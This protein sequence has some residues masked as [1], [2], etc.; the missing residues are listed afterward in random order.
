MTV[1]KKRYVKSNVSWN[2]HILHGTAWDCMGLHGTV[3]THSI[4]ESGLG[5]SMLE[6]SSKKVYKKWEDFQAALWKC[7]TSW[8]FT[9]TWCWIWLYNQV[10][11]IYVY[12]VYKD[13]WLVGYFIKIRACYVCFSGV[14]SKRGFARLFH[15]FQVYHSGDAHYFP[16]WRSSIWYVS[17]SSL[18][19]KRLYL[20]DF[21]IG[22]FCSIPMMEENVFPNW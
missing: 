14:F 8:S 17:L 7:S 22:S 3:Y 10:Y 13:W 11:L 16:K 12:V 21:H 2:H 4:L 5:T 9:A 20:G 15:S 1:S 19:Y 6:E 18:G